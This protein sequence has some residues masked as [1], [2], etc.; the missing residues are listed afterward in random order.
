MCLSIIVEPKGLS[1]EEAESIIQSL[2][3]SAALTVDL[4]PCKRWFRK[5]PPTLFISEDG[6]CACDMLTDEADWNAPTWELREEILQP[7]ADTLNSL[8]LRL[9]CEFSVLALWAG[10][11]PEEDVEISIRDLCGLIKKN[12]V[13]TK[14]RYTIVPEMRV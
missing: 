4:G 5:I 7:L 2:N 14:T 8:C 9:P 1:R 6:C 12:M 13:G 3:D 11:K 10:D